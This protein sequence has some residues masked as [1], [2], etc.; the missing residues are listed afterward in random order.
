[1]TKTWSEETEGLLPSPP[2]ECDATP[3]AALSDHHLYCIFK[4][5]ENCKKT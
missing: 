4:V 3:K 1:M 2:L 5:D